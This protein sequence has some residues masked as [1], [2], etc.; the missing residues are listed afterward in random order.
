MGSI[1]D[2]F[3][4][5]STAKLKEQKEQED[6][7]L[8]SGKGSDFLTIE[9]GLNKFRIFPKHE[10]E[11][12]YSHIREY[13]WVSYEKDGEIKRTNVPNS[14]AHGGTDMDIIEEYIKF[15]RLTLD[16]SDSD[17]AKKLKDMVS[18]PSGIHK[19][20]TWLVYANK[21]VKNKPN[22]FGI[23]E[24]KK[25]VRDGMNEQAII[26][27]E[28]E[29][30]ELDPFTDPD[31]GLPVLIT[32]DSKAKKAADYYKVQLAKNKMALTDEE[33]EKFD[34]VQ[35]LSKI[36]LLQYNL[37][38][39]ETA[40]EGIRI[41]DEEHE[42]NLFESDTFQA[43]IEEVKAQYDQSV[44]S[45][46]EKEGKKSSKTT[47]K[48]TAGKKAAVKEEVEDDDDTEETEDIE[49]EDEDQEDEDQEVQE[50]DE[51][52]EMDRQQLIKTLRGLDPEVKIYKSTEDDSLREQIRA[53]VESSFV[54]EDEED[55]EEAEEEVVEEKPKKT[56]AKS[57]STVKTAAASTG[58]N[59]LSL[60]A[61][62]A[63]LA[64]DKGKK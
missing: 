39:F 55:E 14:I 7:N 61:I 34:K 6:A 41:Y 32:Y 21:I 37:T 28:S 64:A 62:K 5:T 54:G 33:L 38:T 49:Q 1:R 29:A 58:G 11:E 45:R 48:K 50:G 17:D 25:T 60:E 4:A 24:L 15:C 44:G 35:P 59:K 42:I 13:H 3:Q 8:N 63:K 43:I 10:G 2:R 47:T 51:Y 18:F 16:A 30:M 19:S 53:L 22:E 20:T 36:G 46:D 12:S 23:L 31:D 26:E 40:L 52:D 56:V 27:D 57:A 9:D